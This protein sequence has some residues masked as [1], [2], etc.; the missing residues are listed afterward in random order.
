MLAHVEVVLL[1]HRLCAAQV[2]ALDAA[3]ERL[4][5]RY[6]LGQPVVIRPLGLLRCVLYSVAARSS[7]C[8]NPQR[9]LA[10]WRSE[11]THM[12]GGKGRTRTWYLSSPPV[13]HTAWPT[14]E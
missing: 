5:S 8:V 3:R 4:Y 6:V 1:A 7:Y 2:R 14:C 9:G 11:H 10:G 13:S 12:R